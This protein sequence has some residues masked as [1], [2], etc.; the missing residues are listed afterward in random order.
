MELLT[1]LLHI[2]PL[3]R[4]PPEI[5]SQIFSYLHPAALLEASRVS[6]AWRART[7]DSRL[8]RQKY[9][10]EGWALDLVEVSNF[11]KNYKLPKMTQKNLSRKADSQG[12]G[13]SQK[14][15]ARDANMLPSL[16]S[17]ATN[18]AFLTRQE[19]DGDALEDTRH[20]S[21]LLLDEE[22]RGDRAQFPMFSPD[23]RAISFDRMDTQSSSRSGE[24][25]SSRPDDQQSS[26]D[27]ASNDSQQEHDLMPN[28]PLVIPVSSNSIRLNY[29]Q[30]YKQKRKLEDNWTAGRFQSFQLPHRDHAEEAHSECVYTI[31]YSGKYLVSGSRDKT[32]RIWDLDTQRLVRRPLSGHKGSVLCLQFDASP[33]EDLVV[34]GS[35]D[36]DVILWQFS[37][38]NILR[39][40]KNAHSESVL[41]LK[42][43]RRFLVTCSK[44]KMIKV[45]NRK[46]LR[47][48]DKNY[49]IR[50]VEG[51]AKFPS[52]II[53]LTR[54]P[55]PS[56]MGQHLT[57]EQLEPIKE[58]SLIMRIDSHSAAVN[59]VHI[60]KDQLVSASGDRLV[61]VFNIH[62]GVNTTICKGH[63]K[64]IACVQYDGKRIVS[65]SSDDT[66][67]IFDPQSQAQVECLRGHSKLVRT[68]QASFGDC[69]GAEEDL[70]LEARES[71]RRYFEA[72]RKGEIPS[73]SVRPHRSRER[74][75]TLRRAEDVMVIGAKLPQGGGGGRWARIVSGS[76]DETVIIWRKTPDGSWMPAHKL[77]Q[78]E[79]LRAAGPPLLARSARQ[80]HAARFA[81]Q[82]AVQ[83]VVQQQQQGQH[84]QAHAHH[85]APSLAQTQPPTTGT[86]TASSLASTSAGAAGQ[87]G[88]NQNPNLLQQGL[89][90]PFPMM[91][92]NHVSSPHCALVQLN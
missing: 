38:G 34:S 5:T 55:A 22:M 1:P 84:H 88:Q 54:I 50:G 43:D 86:S 72:R 63:N 3:L 13:R 9:R 80:E 15:R 46:E 60:Y 83:Q 20:N 76:Y 35:S 92:N 61:K 2:D 70:D 57:P 74:N 81:A 68:I 69:P 48:G 47:P 66:I 18:S 52:Y 33:E 71:D 37:T 42:F 14:K 39:K 10:S 79:A 73:S 78:A 7:L 45:W 75:S 58:Y 11:E 27:A 17:P 49:P 56:D 87:L 23:S 24:E 51:G 90:P 8:W 31:Q 25:S 40:I 30:V 41:S 44:D 4:L 62:T 82:H 77:Q 65:G 26:T 59:A 36:T 6:K 85:Q 16:S 32:L 91:L 12:E 21:D 67:R 19:S 28:D 64:G 29:H 53:D 89:Q